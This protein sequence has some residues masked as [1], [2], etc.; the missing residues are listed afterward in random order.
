MY[1]F[2]ENGNNLDG[3]EEVDEARERVTP[4]PTRLAL[5]AV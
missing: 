5:A 1:V 3:G 2:L 4:D